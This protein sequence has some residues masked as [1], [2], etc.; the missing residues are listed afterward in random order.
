VSL[1]YKREELAVGDQIQGKFD[2]AKDSDWFPGTISAVHRDN[3]TFDIAYDDG[4]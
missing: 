4:E 1:R 3:E 2:G